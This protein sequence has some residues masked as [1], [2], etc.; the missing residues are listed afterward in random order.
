MRLVTLLLSLALWPPLAGATGSFLTRGLGSSGAFT[1]TPSTAFRSLQL[2]AM[3]GLQLGAVT[4]PILSLGPALFVLATRRWWRQLPDIA[5]GAIGG[6]L[7]FMLFVGYIMIFPLDPLLGGILPIILVVLLISGAFT[8]FLFAW[9][10]PR[11]NPPTSP[12]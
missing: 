8:G 6:L 1:E 10:R 7:M 9:L 4:S 3:E 5:S 12:P 11:S 2:A